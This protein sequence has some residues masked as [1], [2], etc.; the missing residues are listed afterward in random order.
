MQEC[1]HD[2]VD[3]SLLES[4]LEE[5]AGVRG[6]LISILQKTPEIYG[7]IPMD[8]VYRILRGEA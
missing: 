3:L 6:S 1:K 2:S 4:T 5:Y 8:A 7:Y